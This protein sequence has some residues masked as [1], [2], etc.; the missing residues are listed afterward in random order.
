[1]FLRGEHVRDRGIYKIRLDE[2]RV[3]L[4]IEEAVVAMTRGQIT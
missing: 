2:Q 1:M 4:G 3:L